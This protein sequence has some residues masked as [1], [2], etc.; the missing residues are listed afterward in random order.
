MP[1]HA[2]ESVKTQFGHNQGEIV[3]ENKLRFKFRWLAA[4]ALPG[5]VIFDGIEPLESV[6]HLVE[7]VCERAAQG[8]VAIGPGGA[9]IIVRHD[10]FSL[11]IHQQGL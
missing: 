5:G 8:V 4:D 10:D 11:W 2:W 3:A 6:R 7:K 9:F 1:S